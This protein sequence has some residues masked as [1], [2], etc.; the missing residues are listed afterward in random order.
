MRLRRGGD[1]REFDDGET[2]VAFRATTALSR[3]LNISKIELDTLLQR[4]IEH[5]PDVQPFVMRDVRAGL[6]VSSFLLR[7]LKKRGVRL[8]H[9]LKKMISGRTRFVVN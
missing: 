2:A 8:D 7:Q 5:N 6:L 1:V 4:V 9:F 3:D